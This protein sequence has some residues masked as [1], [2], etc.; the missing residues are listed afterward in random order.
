MIFGFCIMLD[1]GSG[2]YEPGFDYLVQ[3]VLDY[4]VVDGIM[5]IDLPLD[6]PDCWVSHG[7]PKT[8]FL[9]PYLRTDASAQSPNQFMITNRG[10]GLRLA[11]QAGTSTR[12]YPAYSENVSSGI[13]Q[14]VAAGPQ[15]PATGPGGLGA[16]L[17]AL[18]VMI[19]LARR[20]NG[21]RGDRP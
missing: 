11:K 15:V 4:S 1:S 10:V 2:S 16:L 12:L 19:T 20:R 17:L 7:S 21:P 9:V 6:D 18:G 3:C 5:E 8:Y 14:A 13:V